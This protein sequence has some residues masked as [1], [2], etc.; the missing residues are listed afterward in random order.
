[1]SRTERHLPNKKKVALI[2]LI[3]LLVISLGTYFTVQMA[4]AK[5][6]K[7]QLELGNRYYQEQKYEEAI[8]AYEKVLEIDEKNVEARI[9]LAKSYEALTKVVKARNVLIAGISMVPKEPSIYIE[10]ADLYLSENNIL[11]AI[12][13][14]DKGNTNAKHQRIQEKLSAIG[15][16]LS[17]ISD[18]KEVQIGHQANLKVIYTKKMAEE[19]TKEAQ[20]EVTVEDEATD[21]SDQ[22]QE[23]TSGDTENNSENL[24]A[25]SPEENSSEEKTLEVKP[26][27]QEVEVEAE[28][29]LNPGKAGDLSANK[30]K[31][32]VFSAK[33]EG[34][35][36]VTAKVG[37]IEKSISL[38]VK[39]KVLENL[40]IVASTQKT[41]FGK[42]IQLKAI[43]KDFNG[44]EMEVSPKWSITEGIGT[45]SVDEGAI[46]TF[47]SSEPGEATIVAKIGDIQFTLKLTVEEEQFQLTKHVSGSGSII[48]NPTGS[49]FKNGQSVSLQAIAAEGWEFVGWDGSLN[50]TSV[51]TSILMN[52]NKEVTAV[53]KQKPRFYALHVDKKGEGSVVVSPKSSQYEEGTSVTVTATAADGWVFD[54]WEGQVQGKN[55]TINVVMNGEKSIRAVFIEKETPTP[56]AEKTTIE[57]ETPLEVKKPIEKETPLEVKKPIEK[58]TPLEVK[59]PVEKETPQ[60]VKKTYQLTDT[61]NGQGTIQKSPSKNNYEEG[62]KVTLTATPASGWIFQKWTGD[63]T[64][65]ETNVT[66]T[67]NGS[68]N[69]EAVFIQVGHVD[70]V[71]KNSLT[72]E[73]VSD[74]SIKLRIGNNVETGASVASGTSTSDGHYTLKNVVPGTYTMEISKDHFTTKYQV[75]NIESNKTV[76]QNETIMPVSQEVTD[77]RVV[78][79]WGE[80][81][82]DLDAHLTGPTVNEQS[83]FHV[84]YG[85]QR[86]SE[87]GFTYAQLDVDDTSGKGPETITSFKQID[88]VY[89]YF[90]MNYSGEVGLT[91]SQA[92]VELYQDNVLVRT[93]T[94]PT[95]GSGRYWNVFEINNGQLKVINTLSDSGMQ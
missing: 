66:V 70:G 60:E 17:L 31:V 46:N 65:S 44:N 38:N 84:Y 3:A 93:F 69:I 72:G 48:S 43:G 39:E 18:R 74:A 67:M 58:E 35:E 88:G 25:G 90:V 79:T 4:N 20:N 47:T 37:S 89:R 41:T 78:L 53:F 11:E 12:N 27:T 76:V 15:E 10:L 83:R 63:A 1:M 6:V 56:Q 9:G 28:W 86:Y 21:E 51:Q 75:I 62:T 77:F 80:S 2:A 45:L 61:V 36:K 30:G 32:N 5:T 59:K 85:N 26:V 23:E 42:E 34:T 14:L 68:K 50:S 81:P 40:E 49:Q 57:K 33:Q 91:N 64:G 95:S 22:N 71:I 55:N 82:R 87:D 19:S 13:T 92:K 16:S 7:E 52:G 73:A 8:I 29:D 24:D 54:H 94:V